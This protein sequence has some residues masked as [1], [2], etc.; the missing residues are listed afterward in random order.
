ML[1]DAGYCI[2]GG[3]GAGKFSAQSQIAA[4]SSAKRGYI[5]QNID[6]TDSNVFVIIGSGIGTNA[7]NTFASLQWRETR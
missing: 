5:S 1:I 4:L 7:S 3:Q 6:S 2:A